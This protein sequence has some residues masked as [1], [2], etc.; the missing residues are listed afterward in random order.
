[1][2]ECY[3]DSMKLKEMIQNYIPFNEQ[4]AKDKDFILQAMDVHEDLL[5]RSNP[6]MHF[7]SS[8]WITNQE[9]TKVLMIYHK[10][11]DSWAWCG[12]HADGEED[13]CE[14]ALKELN[15]ETGVNQYRLLSDKP[16]SLEVLTVDGHIKRNAYVSSHLHLNLT[17][18]VEADEKTPL[19]LNKEETKGVKWIPIDLLKQEV[20]EVW[21]MENIYQKLVNKMKGAK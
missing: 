19:I 14:V 4:E 13:L 6:F 20:R 16:F 2:I 21:M 8:C 15:E 9:R 12:G 18:L 10:I 1:M 3:H 17:Y 7:S 11:Y 5:H